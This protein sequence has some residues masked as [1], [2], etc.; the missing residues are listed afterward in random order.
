MLQV[1]EE[2][3]SRS[4]SLLTFLYASSMG[5]TK[6]AR[7]G[8]DQ[9]TWDLP[10]VLSLFW[11]FLELVIRFSDESSYGGLFFLSCFCLFM[12]RKDLNTITR[13]FQMCFR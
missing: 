5:Q 9:E 4:S 7:K 6:D 3:T 11:F 12:F 8:N 10:T 2:R 1:T 13:L